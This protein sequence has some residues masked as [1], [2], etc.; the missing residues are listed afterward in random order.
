MNKIPLFSIL[1]FFV[2]L[3]LTLITSGGIGGFWF[4]MTGL[5]VLFSIAELVARADT[6][7]T[8]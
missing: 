7:G 8:L 1:G 3:R 2:S 5:C 4:I 6:G